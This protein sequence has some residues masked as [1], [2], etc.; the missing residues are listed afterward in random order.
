MLDR[1]IHTLTE[2][3]CIQIFAD[4]KSCKNA[5]REEPW[6]TL[7]YLREG[8]TLT[9]PSLDRLGR[10]IHVP[11]RYRIQPTQAEHRLHLATGS[12]RLHH[13]RRSARVPRVCHAGE[14]HP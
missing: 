7:D 8:D 1:Q 12:A 2:A 5:D 6:K 3:G 10:S 11:H 13:A 9:V 4:K 14:V